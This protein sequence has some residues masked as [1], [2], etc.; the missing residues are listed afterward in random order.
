MYGVIGGSLALK[1]ISKVDSLWGILD[2]KVS[3]STIFK[4]LTD[5][6]LHLVISL[7]QDNFMDSTWA[8]DALVA[9][10]NSFLPESLP[11]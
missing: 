1:C 8:N 9:S 2:R 6:Y 7:I 4:L 3:R 10:L 11:K 5:L